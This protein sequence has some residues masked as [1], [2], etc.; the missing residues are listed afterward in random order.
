MRNI[1]SAASL[2]LLGGLA[3]APATAS[4]ASYI[5][6]INEVYECE[7]VTGC[8]RVPAE[9]INLSELVVLDTDKKLLTSIGI[10]EDAKSEDIEGLNATDKNILLYGTQGSDTWNATVSLED[11]SLAGG[12]A[13]GGSSFSL[14]GKCTNKP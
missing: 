13:S 2:L 1:L 7:A 10:G 6:A 11:G 5:C 12:I 8:H 9:A 14:F 4:A 3:L